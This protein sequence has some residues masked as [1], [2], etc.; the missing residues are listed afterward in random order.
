M[1]KAELV[2]LSTL[3]FA[4]GVLSVV[5]WQATSDNIDSDTRIHKLEAD[6]RTYSGKV[7][8]LQERYDMDIAEHT[9][10]ISTLQFQLEACRK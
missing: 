1:Q 2:V 5:A 10:I 4:N 9:D 3:M 7:Y 6:V 8:D